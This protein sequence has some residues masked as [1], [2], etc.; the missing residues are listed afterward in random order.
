M[1]SISEGGMEEVLGVVVVVVDGGFWVSWIISGERA[2]RSMI[3]W[4][5]KVGR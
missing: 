4:V 2:W 3:G 5:G 1:E